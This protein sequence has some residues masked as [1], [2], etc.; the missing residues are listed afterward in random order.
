[1]ALANATRCTPAQA[2]F[3]FA[4]IEGVTPLSG[5]TDET[6]MREDLE[7]NGIVFPSDCH[8]DLSAVRAFVTG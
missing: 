6:H 5:T 1:M 7:V 4:Q 3:K 2:V 8:N